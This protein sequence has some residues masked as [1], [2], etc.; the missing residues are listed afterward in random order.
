MFTTPSKKNE[1]TT[2][3][4]KVYWKNMLQEM[5]HFES[6]SVPSSGYTGSWWSVLVS[7]ITVLTMLNKIKDIE[8]EKVYSI[9]NILDGTLGGTKNEI[10]GYDR[11]GGKHEV[12]YEENSAYTKLRIILIKCGIDHKVFKNVKLWKNMSL[13]EMFF[14]GKLKDNIKDIC[15]KIGSNESKEALSYFNKVIKEHY[16][17]TS[18]F[19][20]TLKGR[21]LFQINDSPS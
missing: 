10:R 13:K 4:K 19:D 6:I 21:R 20:S 12:S 7:I 11:H 2:S 1:K 9:L 17:I 14:I 8:L 15:E 3:S 5:A 18:M 16:K